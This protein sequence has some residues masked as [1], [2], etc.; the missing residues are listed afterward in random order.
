MEYFTLSYQLSEDSPVYKGLE[1]T[2]VS[3]KSSVE[4]DGYNTY[5]LNLENHSGTHIDA[6]RHFIDNGREIASYSVDE[7]IFKHPMILDCPKGNDEF[8]EVEDLKNITEDVDC[9]FIRTG[10]GDF[11]EDDP[12][13]YLTK[14]PGIKPRT[15]K[16]IRENFRK[17]RCIGM[18]CISIAGYNH[19]KI[20]VE[21]HISAFDESLGVPLLLVE[22]L[23]LDEDLPEL[24]QI[25]IIPWQIKGV[26]SAPCNVIGVLN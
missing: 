3:H 24:D 16:W 6:P 18:D 5:I 9:I 19:G 17:V 23:K 20:G 21:A 2:V 14:N 26:D 25:M 7:L 8:V 10:F 12:N 4:S 11:R 1:K 13:R 15:V 22:D